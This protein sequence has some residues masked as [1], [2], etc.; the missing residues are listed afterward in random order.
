MSNIPNNKSSPFD[1]MKQTQNCEDM[2]NSFN[3]IDCNILKTNAIDTNDLCEEINQI[4]DH[5]TTE[6]DPEVK[7]NPRIKTT[8]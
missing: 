8:N 6:N 5:S 3:Q 2:Q 7:M 4:S 1:S